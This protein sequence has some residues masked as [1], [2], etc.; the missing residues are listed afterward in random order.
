MQLGFAGFSAPQHMALLE[1]PHRRYPNQ[2]IC[3]FL[4]LG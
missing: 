3:Y 2:A 4:G 1:R